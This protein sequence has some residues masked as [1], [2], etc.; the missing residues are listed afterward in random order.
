MNGLEGE[1]AVIFAGVDS[2]ILTASVAADRIRFPRWH[3]DSET[4]AVAAPV[5]AR[6]APAA[7]TTVLPGTRVRPAAATASW[8]TAPN[9]VRERDPVTGQFLPRKSA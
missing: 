9:L 5:P 8:D 3:R 6:Q 1:T 2:L 4:A 7:L